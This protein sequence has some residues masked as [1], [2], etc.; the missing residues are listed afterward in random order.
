MW[1][2]DDNLCCASD[3]SIDLSLKVIALMSSEL[4]RHKK[5]TRHLGLVQGNPWQTLAVLA[6]P[7]G[8]MTGEGSTDECDASEECWGIFRGYIVCKK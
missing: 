6:P 5:A 4:R 2:R 7:K 8:D 3:I 1:L